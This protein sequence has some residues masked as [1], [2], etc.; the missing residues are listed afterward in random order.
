[1]I[2]SILLILIGNIGMACA[3]GSDEEQQFVMFS[4]MAGIVGIGVGGDYPCSVA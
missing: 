3:Y 2:I 1:M 4:I